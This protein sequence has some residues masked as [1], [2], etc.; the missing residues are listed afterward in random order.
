MGKDHRKGS[1]VSALEI[2]SPIAIV[3]VFFPRKSQ[4]SGK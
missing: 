1:G 2:A 4:D 3:V